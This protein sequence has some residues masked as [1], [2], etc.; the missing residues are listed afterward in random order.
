MY[1]RIQCAAT[2]QAISHEWRERLRSASKPGSKTITG[3]FL[4]QGGEPIFQQCRRVA[5]ANF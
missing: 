1:D 4:A 3:Q 5:S 2:H